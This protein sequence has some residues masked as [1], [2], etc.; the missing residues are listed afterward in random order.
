MAWVQGALSWTTSLMTGD[1]Q[2][3]KMENLL[4]FP[5]QGSTDSITT[6]GRLYRLVDS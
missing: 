3:I 4:I 6:T 1:Y 2:E 5:S